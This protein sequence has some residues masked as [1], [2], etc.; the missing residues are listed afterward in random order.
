MKKPFLHLFLLP[1]LL[2]PVVASAAGLNIF[3]CEAEWGALSTEIGGDKISV[4]TATSAMQDVHSV[5]ARPSLI[6][7]LRRADL[8]VCT[9]ASLE[10]GWLPQVQRQAGNNKV[11]SGAGVFFAADQVS[12]LEKPSVLD[13]AN[14][15][16]HPEGNPHVQFDPQRMLQIAT[17]LKDR[18]VSLDPE[19]TSTYQHNYAAFAQKWQQAIPRWQQAAAKLKGR[20]VVVQHST[21]SYLL[22]WLG[23]ES[24]A[25]LEPKPGLPPTTAH[26]QQ[27]LQ[28]I[29]GQPVMAVLSAT[30]QDARPSEWL[31]ERAGINVL[32]LAQSVGGDEASTD[33]IHWYDHVLEQLVQVAK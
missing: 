21:F 32:R 3:A 12:L 2:M 30:Y 17:A 1:V 24:I 33:F 7:K 5:D 28:S 20:K 18:L 25:M 19:N 16:V 9:G 6:A 14:G 10:S 15:D 31:A 11:Q 26:L 13:R 23:I 29:K 4:Y 27:V 8:L 22:N